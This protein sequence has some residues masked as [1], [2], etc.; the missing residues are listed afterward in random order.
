M[1]IILYST[2]CPKCKVLKKK[3]EEEKIEFLENKDVNEMISLGID[4]VP[5]LYVNG[6]LL[7]FVAANKW[8]KERKELQNEHPN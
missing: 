2:D 3:L 6:E 1:D 7:D 8:I 4:Q 5:I